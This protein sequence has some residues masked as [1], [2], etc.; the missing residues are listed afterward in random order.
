MEE[1]YLTYKTN[2][3]CLLEKAYQQKKYYMLPSLIMREGGVVM[4]NFLHNH[5]FLMI[6][7]SELRRGTSLTFLEDTVEV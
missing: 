6:V 7:L 2:D 1:S 4:D 5:M 3:Y